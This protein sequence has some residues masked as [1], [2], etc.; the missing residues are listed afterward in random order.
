MNLTRRSVPAVAVAA[1]FTI[2]ACSDDGAPAGLLGLSIL[3]ES[4]EVSVGA[5]VELQAVGRLEAGTRDLTKAAR[6]TS[7]DPEIAQSLGDGAFV[8]TSLGRVEISAEYLGKTASAM[9][10]VGRPAPD[11]LEL[12]PSEPLVRLS[13]R[14]Q[15]QAW[16]LRGAEREEVTGEVQW[17]SEDEAVLS[18]SAGLVTGLAVG[19]ARVRASGF[20]LSA[21]VE[22]TITAA[23]VVSLDL[24][25]S[26][27]RLLVGE[28]LSLEATA[29]LSDGS[30]VNLTGALDWS[31]GDPAI[32]R[33]SNGAGTKGQVEGRALGSTTVRAEDP[34]SGVSAQVTVEV[35]EP[36]VSSIS[37]S[38]SAATVAAGDLIT[39]RAM[40][41]RSDGT[42]QD[43]TAS[44]QWTSTDT[45]VAVPLSP[46][47]TLR[48][49]IPGQVMISATDLASGISS[50]DSGGS[51]QLTVAPAALRSLSIQPRN[52]SVGAGRTQQFVAF[53]QYGDGT[54]QDLTASVRWGSSNPSVA[55]IDATGLA[56]GL[57]AGQTTISATDLG[58]GIQSGPGS[59][60]LTITP[61]ELVSLAVD[62][63]A[64][65]LAEQNQRAVTATGLFSD[66]STQDL[67]G[68]VTWQSSSPLATVDAAGTVT[69]VTPGMS[70]ITALHPA[71]GIRSSD[72]GQSA[73]VTVIGRVITALAVL[74]R[75]LQLPVGAQAT[76]TAQ[77]TYN[78]LSTGDVS[79]SV[80]WAISS[81]TVAD[82][83]NA[84]NRTGVAQALAAGQATVSVTDVATG[85]SSSA[86][87]ATLTV[88]STVSLVS[89]SVSAP[90]P[91]LLAGG[92]MQL[93][94][95]GTFSDG[96]VY[97][98]TH[99]VTWAS[100]APSVAT[101]SNVAGSRGQLTGFAPGSTVIS[102]Q[103]APGNISSGTGPTI[104]VL[105]PAPTLVRGANTGQYGN[106][107]GGSPFEDACGPNEA[108]IGIRVEV[109]GFLNK[110]GGSCGALAVQ[111]SGG[112]SIVVNAGTV[113]PLRG[114]AAGTAAQ[115]MC[116][117]NQV[118]VGFSSRTGGLVDQLTLRCA[119]LTLTAGGAGTWTVGRGPTTSPPPV[120][121]AGGSAQPTDDCPAGQI[122][123]VARIRA[124]NSVDAFGLGCSTVTVP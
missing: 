45:Q 122:G 70:T 21:E 81:S 27:R 96:N 90:S 40:A 58:T 93:E 75:Q 38:P 112:L 109:S 118:V 61:P 94:A 86:A 60:Q 32:A 33:V 23:E 117:A 34:G 6:W 74:P 44:V 9:I 41:T 91:S 3:P 77:A 39:L 13:E 80:Q 115:A 85:V 48:G 111:S 55:T 124:G 88:S 116:P 56:L 57:S 83:G 100:S 30:Q 121:G 106:L 24:G 72:S 123:T 26:P 16:A 46:A 59:A 113:L 51:A 17:F 97:A 36:T 79:A 101:V 68:A 50:A 8:G 2:V 14:V 104:T 54:S 107:T 82:I 99:A 65:T 43:V 66:G 64:F 4:V 76:L 1:L 98:M 29:T 12:T 73:I 31:A 87:S 108:L 42:L 7:A 114:L 63:R 37:V 84:G 47:G 35:V 110:L 19:R 92:V 18:V 10:E 95:L 52:L 49:V 71:T 25:P 105:V 22:V 28:V 62:P 11:Q 20:G 89:L 119:P 102:A 53:G 103:Y 15:L 78:D 67:T 69:G 120:G 5:Q